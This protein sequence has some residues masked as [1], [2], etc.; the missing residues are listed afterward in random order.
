M[1]ELTTEQRL[2]A[3]EKTVGE[4]KAILD[5]IIEVDVITADNITRPV[6][7][8]RVDRPEPAALLATDKVEYQG[9][10]MAIEE[11]VVEIEKDYLE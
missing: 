7:V 1:A 5:R 8:I 10:G 11:P 3:L 4:L 6:L 2:V 9:K